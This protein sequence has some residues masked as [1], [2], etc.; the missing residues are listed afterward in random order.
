MQRA[1]PEALVTGYA[2][3]TEVMRNDP[4][5]R[6]VLAAAVRAGAAVIVTN[7]VRDFPVEACAP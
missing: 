7:N 6:H 1:F 3:L 2:Y 4:R 5:D